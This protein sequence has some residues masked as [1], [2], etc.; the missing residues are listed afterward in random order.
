MSSA[1]GP[2]HCSFC[3]TGAAQLGKAAEYGDSPREHASSDEPAACA[4]I[5]SQCARNSFAAIYQACLMSCVPCGFRSN[6]WL[7]VEPCPWLE[8][9]L[10]PL[11]LKPYGCNA[12]DFEALSMALSWD[13]PSGLVV[14]N[15][16]RMRCIVC[17]PGRP[18]AAIMADSALSWLRR[19][20]ALGIVIL[21]G[22]RYCFL[23]VLWN[24]FQKRV[25]NDMRYAQL[26]EA[27]QYR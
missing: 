27:M 21:P 10:Q 14:F 18:T 9:V 23:H 24:P 6:G 1:P 25:T 5:N 16:E 7:V 22:A 11:S 19:E 13:V 15:L 8:S 4:T 12:F 2:Q 20:G 17:R 3:G 26:Y